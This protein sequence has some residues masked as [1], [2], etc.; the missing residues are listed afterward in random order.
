MLGDAGSGLPLLSSSSSS[1]LLPSLSGEAWSFTSAVQLELG[2]LA[3]ALSS[4]NGKLV[5]WDTF[6][7][8]G[9]LGWCLGCPGAAPAQGVPR[10]STIAGAAILIC[11]FS[12]KSQFLEAQS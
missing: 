1:L 5:P 4:S 11:G 10:S 12:P 7:L 8:L 9:P 2:W 3:V 6:A